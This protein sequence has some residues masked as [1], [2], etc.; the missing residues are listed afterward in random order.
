M[1]PLTTSRPSAPWISDNRV[2]RP[3]RVIARTV[4]IGNQTVYRITR[5]TLV[6]QN[7]NPVVITSSTGIITIGATASSARPYRGKGEAR[8]NSVATLAGINELPVEEYLYGVVPQELGPI[9]FPEF[10]AQKAQA[11]A[12]RTYAI[13]G[14]GK[15]AGDG[16]D[17][18][19]TPERCPECGMPASEQTV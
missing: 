17:L 5:G 2:R 4:T 14:F 18:R 8:I 19:A 9:A 15:R 7:V 11:V 1:V 10:E 3:F 6:V 13:A 16:Y 12:A